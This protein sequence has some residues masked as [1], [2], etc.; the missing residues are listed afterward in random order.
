MSQVI[1]KAES[2]EVFRHKSLAVNQCDVSEMFTLTLGTQ[3]LIFKLCDLI[4][5]KKKIFD[6][7]LVLL[8]DAYHRDMDIIYLPHI[9][10]HLILSL[11]EI[12]NLR[13]LLS[14]TFAML[15]INSQVQR[16]LYNPFAGNIAH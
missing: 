9:D 7:D 5:F 11:E 6:I 15:Q 3:Q 16:S 8:F 2:E 4:S 14:G 12:L 1:I 13:E 10:R